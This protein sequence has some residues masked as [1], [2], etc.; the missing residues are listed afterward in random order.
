MYKTVLSLSQEP[1]DNIRRLILLNN[2]EMNKFPFLPLKLI[3]YILCD[4]SLIYEGGLVA[5]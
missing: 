1:K 3:T 5:N 2:F 4:W